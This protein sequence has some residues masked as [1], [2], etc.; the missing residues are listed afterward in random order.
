MAHTCA[1][2]LRGWPV[3]RPAQSVEAVSAVMADRYATAA[4]IAAREATRAAKMAVQ[5]RRAQNLGSRFISR[6]REAARTGSKH[7]QVI[8]AGIVYG[9]MAGIASTAKYGAASANAARYAA[10]A[11]RK[12]GAQ[13]AA[14]RAARAARVAAGWADMAQRR[15]ETSHYAPYTALMTARYA[16]HAAAAARNAA[17]AS[18][19][20]G[21]CTTR[22]V[23]L[24]AAL[25]PPANRERY[26]EEWKSDL[27]HLPHRRQRARFVPSMLG[28]AMRLAV[29]LRQP[30]S[31]SRP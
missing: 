15:A 22:A 25:L 20:L 26:T 4:A 28:G 7:E 17:R 13:R 24:A 19:P 14:R 16:R 10:D 8:E 27:C 21:R 3:T 18:G 31:R 23:V 2:Y 9:Q 29:V 12:A 5:P 11:A 6:A 30:T 1:R